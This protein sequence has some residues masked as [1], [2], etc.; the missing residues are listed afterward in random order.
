[1]PHLRYAQ[2]PL[3]SDF[4]TPVGI[5]RVGLIVLVPTSAQT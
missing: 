5:T 3:S 1:M 4:P 2:T